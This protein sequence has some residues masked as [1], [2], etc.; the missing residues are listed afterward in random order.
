MGVVGVVAAI[1]ILSIF[2]I[3]SPLHSVIRMLPDGDT[4]VMLDDGRTITTLAVIMDVTALI[5][6]SI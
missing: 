2:D 4:L 5:F 3:L 6:C 1:I